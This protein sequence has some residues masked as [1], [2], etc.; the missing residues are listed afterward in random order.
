MST[1]SSGSIVD[2]DFIKARSQLL[3]LA[4][5]LD[6]AQRAEQMNDYRIEALQQALE[7]LSY[8]SSTELGRTKA[9]L[10]SLSD[11]STVPIE[12]AQNKGAAG[13]YNAEE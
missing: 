7:L 2:K 13:A 1:I 5:F 4:A 9:V 12:K 10:E 3:E 8:D 11:K 6:R